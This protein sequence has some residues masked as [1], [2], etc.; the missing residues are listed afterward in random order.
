MFA[1]SISWNFLEFEIDIESGFFL[2]YI[3]SEVRHGKEE[4]HSFYIGERLTSNYYL[5]MFAKIRY[6]HRWFGNIFLSNI[7]FFMYIHA[8]FI[9]I[10]PRVSDAGEL[11]ASWNF[12]RHHI[13][14]SWFL[15]KSKI[16]VTAVK[17]CTLFN[18][19]IPIFVWNP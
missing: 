16:S 9:E 5:K 17:W 12:E 18:G 6:I 19:K 1:N 2:Y 7:W 8:F 13:F 4:R 14:H 3:D 15:D 10:I 11:K